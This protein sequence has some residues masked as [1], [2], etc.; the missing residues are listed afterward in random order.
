MDLRLL[1]L[2][3]IIIFTAMVIFIILFIFLYQKRYYRHLQEKEQLKAQ[4]S[5][6]LLQTQ[7]EIQE[8]TLKNIAQEIHDNIGQELSLAKLNLSTAI[9]SGTDEMLGKIN[10][11]KNLVSKA[12]IDLRNLSHG[13]NMD[14]I[15]QMGLHEAIRTE[16][17]LINKAGEHKTR[18]DTEGDMPALGAQKELI[19]FRIVQETLHNIFKHA[20]AKNITV[21]IKTTRE[22]FELSVKDDGK[23]FH[24]GNDHQHGT[25]YGMGLRNMENRAKLIN[26]AFSL[27]SKINNGTEVKLTL[28]LIN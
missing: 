8:Q 22:Q 20:E 26:A 21:S 11:S 18:M 1:I 4:F 23:G 9:T 17:E 14:S 7:L 10:T 28:P 19:I 13:L 15:S 2:G 5:Q 6:E 24:H 27:N 12:I 25:R 16:L 3:G